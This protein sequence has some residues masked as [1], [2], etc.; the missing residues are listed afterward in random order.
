MSL[1]RRA[2]LALARKIAPAR[3]G[4]RSFNAAQVGRLTADWIAAA[5]SA[6][7]EIRGAFRRLVDR[8]R[9]LERNNDYMRGFLLSAERNINGAQ[10]YDL[11]SDAGEWINRPPRRHQARAARVAA[12]RHGQARH[13]GCVV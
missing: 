3:T 1:L 6:D 11:R 8:S 7:S 2:R 4:S 9:D 12:R 10:R 13:R 5:T